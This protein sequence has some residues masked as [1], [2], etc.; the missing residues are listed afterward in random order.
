MLRD[1][2]WFLVGIGI[3]AWLSAYAFQK[4]YSSRIWAAKEKVILQRFHAQAQKALK[5]ATE[6]DTEIHDMYDRRVNP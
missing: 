2:V 5:E 1:M 4:H 3:G 6:Y